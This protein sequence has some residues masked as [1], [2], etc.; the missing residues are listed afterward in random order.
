M[1]ITDLDEGILWKIFLM[2]ADLDDSPAHDHH[3]EPPATGPPLSRRPLTITLRTSQVCQSWRRLLLGSTSIWGRLIHL[4]D[5][6]KKSSAWKYEV[7]R[8]GSCASKVF[9]VFGRMI[10]GNPSYEPVYSRV[11]PSS[12]LWFEIPRAVGIKRQTILGF[13]ASAA[14]LFLPRNHSEL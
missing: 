2:N 9:P 14:R 6:D 12:G 11:I 8:E 4:D 10:Y 13:S 5:L 7:L 1:P 3:A